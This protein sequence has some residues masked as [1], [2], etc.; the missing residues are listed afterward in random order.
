MSDARA[1]RESLLRLRAEIDT[2]G[3]GDD[4]ARARLRRLVEEIERTLEAPRGR[5]VAIAGGDS[6]LVAQLKRSVLR[7]EASHPRIAG[8]MNEVVEQLGNMGI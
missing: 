3:V 4:E 1:L 6:G 8:L 2:L 5:D 7:F